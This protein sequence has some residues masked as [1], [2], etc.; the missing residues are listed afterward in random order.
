MIARSYQ[1]RAGRQRDMFLLSSTQRLRFG[2]HGSGIDCR[3]ERTNCIDSWYFFATAMFR[4]LYPH[5]HAMPLP[6]GEASTKCQSNTIPVQQIINITLYSCVRFVYSKRVLLVRVS[7]RSQLDQFR[8]AVGLRK[9]WMNRVGD[10]ES[11][12]VPKHA[13]VGSP[14]LQILARRVHG[15]AA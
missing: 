8:C 13:H 3:F 11:D 14:H 9:E 5:F 12:N 4:T 15:G 10:V 2:E 1:K 7:T 6:I